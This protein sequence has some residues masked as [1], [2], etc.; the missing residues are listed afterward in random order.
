MCLYVGG[1]LYKQQED[2]SSTQDHQEEFIN[3]ARE[4]VNTRGLQLRNNWSNIGNPFP[5]NFEPLLLPYLGAAGAKA[6]KDYRTKAT[7]DLFAGSVTLL[8]PN[9]SPQV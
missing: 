4:N 7:K 9:T 3:I 1:K 5:L 6:M 2:G 8:T